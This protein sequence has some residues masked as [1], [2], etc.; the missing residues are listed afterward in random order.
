MWAESQKRAMLVSVRGANGLPVG[1][2]ISRKCQPYIIL[3]V[4]ESSK[5]VRVL[6]SYF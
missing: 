2:P 6:S 4:V 1:D 5:Q 3:T